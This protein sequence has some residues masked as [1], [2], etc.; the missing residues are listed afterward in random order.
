M[1]NKNMRKILILAA[2]MPVLATAATYYASP[3]GTGTGSEASPC[4]LLSGISKV[5]KSTNVLIL[6]R[7]RY[8]LTGAIGVTGA[9]ANGNYAKI[10]GETG[11]PA[12]V[13]LDAQDGSEVMRLNKNI[14]LSGVT[15]MNGCNE[16]S[17]VLH[18]AAGVRIGY[19]DSLSTLSI[20]SN[21]VITCCTNAFTAS[22]KSGSDVVYGGAVCVYDIVSPLFDIRSY[23]GYGFYIKRFI[24][25]NIRL[26]YL[27]AAILHKTDSRRAARKKDRLLYFTSVAILKAGGN[28]SACATDI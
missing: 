7:G 24:G 14:L 20:V 8:A 4:S 17:T 9:G 15:M 16:S 19:S 2:M 13:I 12:D 21:C 25:R 11:D 28:V 3:D 6:K 22:T 27:R 23:N 10:F 26:D 1:T 5:S 18:R